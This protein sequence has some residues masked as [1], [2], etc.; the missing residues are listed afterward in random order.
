MKVIWLLPK[1]IKSKGCIVLWILKSNKSKIDK[2]NYRIPPKAQSSSN[3]AF[4]ASSLQ[5]TSHSPKS[6]A[7]WPSNPSN[8]NSR[9]ALCSA[10]PWPR[11]PERD[12]GWKWCKQAERRYFPRLFTLRAGSARLPGRNKR[13][14]TRKVASCRMRKFWDGTLPNNSRN[15]YISEVKIILLLSLLLLFCPSTPPY[16]TPFWPFFIQSLL[17]L[18]QSWYLLYTEF[19]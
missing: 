2:N 12:T 4:T 5:R 6:S 11:L 9:I 10:R 13:K 19:K 7:N 17:I 16:T 8:A 3:A 15:N 18:F 14:Q 1:T